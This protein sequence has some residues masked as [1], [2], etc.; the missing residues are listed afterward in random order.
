MQIAELDLPAFA[1]PG[2]SGPRKH[3]LLQLA[4][5]ANLPNSEGLIS[6][7]TKAHAAEMRRVAI[8]WSKFRPGLSPS[9]NH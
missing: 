1:I 9:A 7:P 5:D 6:A 4:A 3:W 8:A 2:Y